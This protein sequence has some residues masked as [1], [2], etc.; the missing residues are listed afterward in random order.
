[1]YILAPSWVTVNY[2]TLR[3]S[4]LMC[5]QRAETSSE[6]SNRSRTASSTEERANIWQGITI[7]NKFMKNN[8]T[9]YPMLPVLV[10][11]ILQKINHSFHKYL[12][13][14]LCIIWHVLLLHQ[15]FLQLL[16]T[17]ERRESRNVVHWRERES[18]IYSQYYKHHG[19]YNS[20]Q[21][22]K[23]QLELSTENRCEI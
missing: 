8:V 11:W 16:F 12:I 15:L 10:A 4:A 19:I 6:R 3:S 23:K 18:L 17:V 22:Q 14:V 9:K 2:W 20:K 7:F 21:A 5:L 1:M 13:V